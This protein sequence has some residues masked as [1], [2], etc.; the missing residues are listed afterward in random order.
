MTNI[1]G[2]QLVLQEHIICR[3]RDYGSWFMIFA[4]TFL[5]VDIDVPAWNEVRSLI[6]LSG[7]AAF[8]ALLTCKFIRMLNNNESTSID[9]ISIKI[10]SITGLLL[11]FVM[12]TIVFAL[13]GL[14]HPPV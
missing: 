14:I 4:V 13:A 7:S 10:I 11:L 9:I 8:L 12:V 3:V 2:A 5:F 1:K 6:V